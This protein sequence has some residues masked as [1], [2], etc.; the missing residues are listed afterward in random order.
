VTIG[1]EN[2]DIVLAD[3]EVSRRHARIV[4]HAGGL[5]I[6]DLG[7][8]NGTYV[9]A[10]KLAGPAPLAAGDVVTMGDS[11]LRVEVVA[12]PGATRLR[13]GPAGPPAT[14]ATPVAQPAAPA[15]APVQTEPVSADQARGDV[16]APAPASASRVHQTLPPVKHP[17]STEF[18]PEATPG[19]GRRGSAATRTEATLI[20][21]GVVLTT[22]AAVTVYLIQR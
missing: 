18:R 13:R 5:A 3:T 11:E 8:T 10:V 20:S 4:A 22:A 14:S 17:P 1:R 2:C 16:P 21:Y 6:E 15:V 7:S 9:N 12:D 19:G